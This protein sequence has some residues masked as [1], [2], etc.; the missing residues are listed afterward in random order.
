M[1]SHGA[2][3]RQ[4]GG[5]SADSGESV[6]LV[7][8]VHDLLFRRTEE[9]LAMSP[10]GDAVRQEAHS[11]QRALAGWTMHWKLWQ[12]GVT[13]WLRCSSSRGCRAAD[14]Q[15]AAASWRSV[16]TGLPVRGEDG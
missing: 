8:Q 2:H 5:N 14:G 3:S 4:V 11:I 10:R 15:V 9:S 6:D 1:A 7:I 13:K 12:Q 16:G